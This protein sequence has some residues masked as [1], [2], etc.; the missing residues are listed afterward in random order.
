MNK[1]PKDLNA[2]R[3]R[4]EVQEKHGYDKEWNWDDDTPLIAAA[5]NGH[6]PVVH[7]L[8]IQNADLMRKSCPADDVHETAVIAVENA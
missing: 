5:R 4:R 8:I 2:C 3:K 7:E 6:V 1:S